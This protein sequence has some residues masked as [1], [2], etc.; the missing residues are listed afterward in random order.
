MAIAGFTVTGISYGAQPLL[1]AVSS[2]V[3]PRRYRSWGQAA[4][5]IANAFGGITALLVSGAFTRT[6]NIPSEGFRNFWYVGTG[7]YLF[8][9]VLCALLY[10]PPPTER[11]L[12]HSLGQKLGKLDWVGYL[13]LTAGI[14]LFCIGLSWSENPY[15]WADP[16]TSATFAAGLF[17]LALL[18]I[19]ET[20]FKK[21]GMLHHGLFQNRNFA[22][23]LVCIFCEGLAFFGANN[24][25]AFQVGVLYETDA[26]IVSV[27]YSITMIVSIFSAAG[28]G[29]YCARTKRVRWITVA[30]F[31]V[32]VIFFACMAN[33]SPATSQQVWGYPVFLGTAL[34]MSL[35]AL[36]TAA[37]LSTPPELIAITSGLIIGI[38]S[39]G[40]SVGLAI[41]NALFTDAM[42]HLGD[43]IAAAVIPLGLPPNATG[44]FIGALTSHNEEAL[45]QIPG[46]TPQIVGAGADALL[47]TYTT[48]FK[49]VWIAAS[50]FVALAAVLA[51]FLKDQR[52]EFN[53]HIDAPIEGEES[54]YS[55]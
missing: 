10:H 9:S 28:A 24:Y 27:R 7:L 22:I 55:S 31:L 13:L 5:L 16:H 42:G 26:L 29:L 44:A 36:V 6:S 20:F 43:N 48:G 45:F 38:R 37:Q 53:M 54:L 52:K 3:L 8:A 21:D 41:Y 47:G 33:S 11:Q 23:A 32:F 17:A 12:A 35:V 40:G 19:N 39:L 15:P 50:C 34:G 4:D 51:V 25:F 49:H 14:V 30:S 18:A 2:E 46:V 1:H